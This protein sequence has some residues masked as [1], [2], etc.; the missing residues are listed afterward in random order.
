MG[1]W[2]W[3]V[4]WVCGFSVWL[5]GG[6]LWS[7]VRDSEDERLAAR[8]VLFGGTLMVMAVPMALALARS[9]TGG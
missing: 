6:E 3:L 8:V 4:A 2:L 7:R 5:M 1:E 9:G